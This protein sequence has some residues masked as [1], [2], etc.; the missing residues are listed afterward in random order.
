MQ[1]QRR[2]SQYQKPF[3][4]NVLDRP[5]PVVCLGFRGSTKE[6]AVVIALHHYALGIGFAATDGKTLPIL[7]LLANE[8]KQQPLLPSAGLRLTRR[9]TAE[10]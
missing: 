8:L 5:H 1:R 3:R 4:H 2:P 9:E 10:Q 6:V 7:V